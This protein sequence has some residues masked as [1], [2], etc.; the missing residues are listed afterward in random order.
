MRLTPG[1]DPQKVYDKLAELVEASN[2]QS[3]ELAFEIVQ[4]SSCAAS[5]TSPEREGF[6][7]I[8]E[9]MEQYWQSELR[10]IPLLGGTLPSDAFT[11]G[12]G[13]AAYWLPAANSNNRQHDTNEHFVLE[14]FFRQQEFYERLVSTPYH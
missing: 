7:W 6:A 4:S 13:L 9:N 14:H 3:T 12:L 5:F 1:L 10:V 8:K 2:R 11:D